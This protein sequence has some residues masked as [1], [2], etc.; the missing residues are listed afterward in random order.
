ML[1]TDILQPYMLS[2]LQ[3]GIGMHYS[4]PHCSTVVWLTDYSS[5]MPLYTFNL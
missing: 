2:A 4:I 3:H 1:Y 5:L